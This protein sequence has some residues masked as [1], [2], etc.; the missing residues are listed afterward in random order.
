MLSVV[1]PTLTGREESL[2]RTISA[3]EE[4][5]AGREWELIVV[6]DKPTWPTACNEGYADT[7]GDILHFSADDLEPLPG[8][9]DQVLPWLEEHDELPAPK[10]L[11][12]SA[13]GS[14][15]NIEDGPD[16]SITW[17][18]R[19][20]LLRRDQYERIGRW[21]EYN[22]VADIW[23][24]EKA[25]KIGI[26]T[27]IFYSYAFVHHWHQVGRKEDPATMALAQIALAQLRHEM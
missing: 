9:W 19:I 17:F 13:D 2:Q 21:P 7:R 14:F 5:L 18:T 24:S 4:T 10:V 26:E 22:Y 6:Q 23:L 1:V 20:P 16:G 15:D 27:R 11:N 12:H 25:R 3:Y 8:C